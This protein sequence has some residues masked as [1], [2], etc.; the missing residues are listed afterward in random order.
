MTPEN[1]ILIVTPRMEELAAL[2]RSNTLRRD[3]IGNMT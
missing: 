3:F 2:C 1:N